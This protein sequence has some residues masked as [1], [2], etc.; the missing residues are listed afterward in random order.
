MTPLKLLFVSSEVEPFAKTGGLADVA[1]T[2]PLALASLGCEVKV[3]LPYYRQT[4][5]QPFGIKL[6]K[7]NIAVKLGKRLNR[8]SLYYCRRKGVDFYFIRKDKYFNRRFMYGTPKADY[9]DNAVR[10][11]FFVKSILASVIAIN[12]KSDIIHCNDWQT[13]L[14]PFYLKNEMQGSAF[15]RNAKIIFTIHNLTY[16]GLFPRKI[17]QRVGVSYDFFT[18]DKLKFHEK[19]SFIKSGILYADAITTVSKRYAQE[20]L[21]K[22]FG[23]GLEKELGKRK[24]KLY[25]IVNGADYS[26][27]NPSADR[28]IAAAYDEKNLLNKTLCKRDLLTQMGLDTDL[29]TPLL[30]VIGRLVEQKGIDLI[31]ASADEIKRL[32]CSLVIL[33]TRNKRYQKLMIQLSRKY[34]RNIAVKLAFDNALAHKIEAGCDIFVMPSR[35][36][37]CGLNQIYSL[38]YGTIPVVSAVGGLDDTIIDYNRNPETG[39]GF[40]FHIDNSVDFIHTLKRALSVYKNRKEWQRLMIRGMGFDFSWGKSAK[41]Y[42]KLY[43]NI[44]E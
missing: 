30:G 4:K 31:A 43:R 28:F 18:S 6:L 41:E 11:A 7:K 29:D 14:I 42:L 35:Y 36:E 2:L 24:D 9:P 1:G 27:W 16:Q 5:K 17:M 32:G 37:P 22:K 34:P 3:F 23:C 12:Y 25:G 13:A 15:F 38:K 44:K 33:G 21:T 39:N 10:F 20:I 40:K 8:C 26:E 19:F